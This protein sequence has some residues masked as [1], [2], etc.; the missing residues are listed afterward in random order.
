MNTM[1]CQIYIERIDASKNMKRFYIVSLSETLLSEVCVARRWGRIGTR[2]QEKLHY[3]ARELD[4]LE[5]L[6]GLLNGK[7]KRGYSLKRR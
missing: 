2:G 1:P 3:F 5:F 7:R 4:A 6:L